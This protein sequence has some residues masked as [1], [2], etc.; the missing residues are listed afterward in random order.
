MMLHGFGGD[1]SDW[2][3]LSGGHGEWPA[4]ALDLP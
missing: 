2:G 4:L 1:M 3:P